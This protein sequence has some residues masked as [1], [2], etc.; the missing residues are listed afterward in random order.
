MYFNYKRKAI[1]GSI[2]DLPPS[3]LPRAPAGMEWRLT[4][5]ECQCFNKKFFF[6]FKKCAGRAPK[7]KHVIF[8]LCR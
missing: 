3:I 4:G 1:S 8:C 6:S 7:R 5:Q 2:P